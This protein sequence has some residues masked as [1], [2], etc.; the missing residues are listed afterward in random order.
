[1]KI[2]DCVMS[3][4]GDRECGEEEEEASGNARSRFLR[5]LFRGRHPGGAGVMVCVCTQ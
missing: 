2:A 3:W 1:M 5:F 4:G